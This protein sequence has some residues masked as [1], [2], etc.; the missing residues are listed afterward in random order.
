MEH[1]RKLDISQWCPRK[2]RPT[3]STD[4]REPTSLKSFGKKAGKMTLAGMQ[5]Y[6]FPYLGYFGLIKHSDIFIIADNV[7]YIESG[8]IRRNRILKPKEGWQYIGVP[9][10]KCSHKT[11]I[12]DI[13]IKENEPWRDKIFRQLHH[14]SKKAPY[15]KEVIRFLEH[16]FAIET[17]S[18]S[19]LNVHLLVET[20]KYI[21]IPFNVE[22]FSQMTVDVK[23]ASTADEWALNT[24][25]ALGA[26]TYINPPGGIEF[27]DSRKYFHVGVELEFLKVNLRPYDQ[28]NGAFEKG[29]SILDVMM[30]N[31]PQQIHTMLDDYVKLKTSGV[32]PQQHVA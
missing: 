23:R 14:Y 2:A 28:G 4:G 24:C 5:P 9:V 17:D 15:Y 22:I 7:Q 26:D 19:A 29:L 32:T 12:N 3:A 30:F 31:S 27:Y 20:C 13:K 25:K 6:F 21:G 18:I 10:V 16:A 11:I 8:W 1:A